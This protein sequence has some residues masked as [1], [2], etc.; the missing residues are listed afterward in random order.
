M[1]FRN[2]D[3]E[4]IKGGNQLRTLQLVDKYAEADKNHP[5]ITLSIK[6]YNLGKSVSD[7]KKIFNAV[8]RII[9]FDPDPE[10]VQVVRTV[11]RTLKDQR[12]NCV[13]YTVIFSAFLRALKI[14]HVIRIVEYP[15]QIKPGFSHIYAKTLDGITLDAV[16]GQDQTG[17][18]FLRQN[19]KPFFNCEILP[20]K[21][22]I[23][24]TI[25]P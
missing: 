25:R 13:D 9:S 22:K 24:K 16:V 21:N 2:R 5:F 19:R 11:N 10:N 12:G 7:L 8:H 4:V 3:I 18:E 20:I 6:K 15:G 1:R 17:N 14:P 23:D